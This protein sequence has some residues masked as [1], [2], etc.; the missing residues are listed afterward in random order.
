[1][2]FIKLLMLANFFISMSI[3]FIYASFLA[4]ARYD[5]LIDAKDIGRST[6]LKIDCPGAFLISIIATRFKCSIIIVAASITL[7][8]VLF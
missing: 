5:R 4:I 6:R 7:G 1:M 8:E 3:S 2:F